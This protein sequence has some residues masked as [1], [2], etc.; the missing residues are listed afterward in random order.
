MF[1]GVDLKRLK[2][3]IFAVLIAVI[4]IIPG[5]A[6]FGEYAG[7]YD[8]GGGYDYDSYDY[9]YDYDDDD[10]NYDYGN[11]DYNGGYYYGGSSGEY[12]TGTTGENG[13]WF[14]GLLVL[15]GIGVAIFFA[16]RKTFGKSKKS[17]SAPVMPGAQRT[18]P[19]ELRP[20]SEYTAIDPTFSEKEFNEKLSN[21]Y[22]RFQNAWQDKNLDDIRPYLTDAFFAQA[23]RQLDAYRRNHQTNRIERISVLDVRLRGWKQ[24]SGNDVIIAELL[25]RIVD[26]VVDDNT[27]NVIR[28][29]ANAEKFMTY[30]WIIQRT[31]GKISAESTG[32]TTRTCPHCGAPVNI[33]H[34]AKCEY[35]DAILTSDTFDWAISNIKGISQR[36]NN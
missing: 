5:H 8:Y 3:M 13:N 28:G 36:T 12:Y 32:V 7:D 11:D 31:S 15:I 9:D 25:T 29:N 10:D 14:L 4:F 24:E 35:C 21:L 26:Y 22:V 27:G 19:S 18:N 20:M 1:G 23:D 16:F 30:E 6:D 2:Y 17:A 33:N 34:S